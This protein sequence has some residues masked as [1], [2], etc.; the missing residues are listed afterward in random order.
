MVGL[1]AAIVAAGVMCS[2]RER[3]DPS[4]GAASPVDTLDGL[5]V[6]PGAEGFG[7]RTRA[8]RGGQVTTVTSLADSGPGTLR[9]ALQDA[10]PKTIV[11][12]VGGIIELKSLLFVA[13]PF[14][15]IAGQ[16][17]PGDGI[18]LKDFGIVVMTND[19]L[20]QSIRVRPGNKGATTR[21]DN[22]KAIAI[23][24]PNGDA[25]GAYNVVVDHVSASWG[26]D[27]TITTW[28][29]AH[30][31]TVSWS[32]ASEA[33][34]SNR[35]P[36]GP[37]SSGVLI[38]HAS[39]RV[40]I[41][42]SLL[43]H[44]R[45]R[46]PLFTAG[47]TH[48]FVNNVVYDWGQ[49]VTE[50]VDNASTSV[51]II[52]NWYRPGPSSKTPYEILINPSG[53]NLVPKVYV[54]GNAKF[55]ETTAPADDWARVQ[56]GWNGN[57]APARFHAS[58][59]VRGAVVSVSPATEAMAL[60]LDG[61]GAIAPHR[62][63]VDRRVVADVRNGS[64]S[65]ISSPDQVGGYPVFDR[66]VVPVDSD[67][68]GIPDEWERRNGLNP[69]NPSDGNADRGDGYTNLETYLHSLMPRPNR[70]SGKQ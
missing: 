34:D 3:S 62:D 8:G 15:T 48:E 53:R 43:A 50:I 4:L 47:G 60:V 46:N 7:T 33:L 54:T 56:F 70:Q 30:D 23:L 22:N 9:A 24:G 6:F 5:P 65:V 64:G 52:G 16:T 39:D 26:E 61:A 36:K 40:S 25:K 17:A 28:F 51:N 55:G 31:V 37:H 12:R 66:G 59:P 67:G 18:V 13:H 41:H 14:V 32:I 63:A 49:L 27:E 45:F 57:G 10:S 11:F 29:G 21:P 69:A 1:L 2:G 38:G 20:I 68:D 58:A 19:V 42:H 35:H 44:N